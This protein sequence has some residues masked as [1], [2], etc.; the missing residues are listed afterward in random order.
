MEYYINY[1]DIRSVHRYINGHIANWLDD[2]GRV[3]DGLADMITNPAMSGKAAYNIYTYLQNTHLTIER[4]ICEM[5]NEYTMKQILFEG[6]LYDID[7]YEYSRIPGEETEQLV[8]HC[9]KEYILFDE[10]VEKIN[11]ILYNINDICTF[12]IPNSE[13]VFIELEN[14]IARENEYQ[15]RFVELDDR[16]SNTDFEALEKHIDDAITYIRSIKENQ[17]DISVYK[18]KDIQALPV[19]QMCLNNEKDIIEYVNK[20]NDLLESAMDIYTKVNKKVKADERMDM[21]CSKIWKGTTKIFKGIMCIY[22]TLTCG[23]EAGSVLYTTG[24]G[25]STIKSVFGGMDIIEGGQDIYYGWNGDIDTETINYLKDVLGEKAYNNI[26]KYATITMDFTMFADF[27]LAVDSW[28]NGFGMLSG[29]TEMAGEMTALESLENVE[30]AEIESVELANAE[31]VTIETVEG[32]VVEI[33]AAAECGSSIGEAGLVE[34][35]IKTSYGKSSGKLNWDNVISKKGETRVEHVKLHE[36]NDFTKV[37]HGVFYGDAKNTIEKAWENRANGYMITSGN[38]DI[39]IIP[40]ENVGYAGGYGCQG[41]N[42]NYITIITQKGTN[43]IISG[44]P[45]NGYKYTVDGIIGG[46]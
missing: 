33:E 31:T 2:I 46:N 7:S 39:Y 24:I 34:N 5:F 43:N 3:C 17:I 9:E 14:L 44:F 21:G 20:N 22:L 1:D 19:Y 35:E 4:L 45:G 40:Y 28:V 36:S 13:T 25:S 32:E 8:N 30:L 38:K 11:K 41:N 27:V 18:E 29:E 42:L 10:T 6:M 26:E 12:E 16:F 37:E 15:E 23:P